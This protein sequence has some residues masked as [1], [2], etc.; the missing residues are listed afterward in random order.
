MTAVLTPKPPAGS[1]AEYLGASSGAPR[2]RRAFSMEDVPPP[3][4]KEP[5]TSWAQY[6]AASENSLSPPM[7]PP[8]AEQRAQPSAPCEPVTSWAEYLAA[9]YYYTPCVVVPSHLTMVSH[10]FVV[11]ARLFR[12]MDYLANCTITSSF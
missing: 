6:L 9:R 3:P 12:P 1:W 4:S 5:A 8:R 11:N 10:I 7:F 2:L